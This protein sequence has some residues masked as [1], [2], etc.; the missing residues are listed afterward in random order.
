MKKSLEYKN[1]YSKK[2]NIIERK[3]LYLVLALIVVIIFSVWF[4]VYL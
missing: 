1:K 4:V 2:E 3:I